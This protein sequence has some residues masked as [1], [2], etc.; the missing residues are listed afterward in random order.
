M[1]NP[2]DNEPIAVDD[3]IRLHDVVAR[4]APRVIDGAS[5]GETESPDPVIGPASVPEGLER[6][7]RRR[8][9]ERSSEQRRMVD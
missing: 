6:H 3:F 2:P 8:E 9:G 5:L 1:L 4:R 7:R